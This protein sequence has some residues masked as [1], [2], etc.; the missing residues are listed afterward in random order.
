[1]EILHSVH[2]YSIFLVTRALRFQHQSSKSYTHSTITQ[3]TLKSSNVDYSWLL[4]SNVNENLPRRFKA[5]CLNLILRNP[6]SICFY[7]IFYGQSFF[8][9][10]GRLLKYQMNHSL[11]RCS[12]KKHPIPDFVI[13]TFWNGRVFFGFWRVHV[14][15][16]QLVVFL[17]FY[18]LN[19][20]RE[21]LDFYT[22]LL[23]KI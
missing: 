9:N 6:N 3:G 22:S 21:N 4:T 13:L 14:F 1:M 17:R 5:V 7:N 23:K 15:S 2:H 18:S 20:G 11:K 19:Y 16:V 10:V 12:R 8:T